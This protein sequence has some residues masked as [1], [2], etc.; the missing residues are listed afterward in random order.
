MRADIT[1]SG[2]LTARVLLAGKKPSENLVDLEGFELP[3][4]T[5]YT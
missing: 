2:D 4:I 5:D 3:T 1:G